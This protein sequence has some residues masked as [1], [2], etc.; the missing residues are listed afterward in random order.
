M[1]TIFWRFVSRNSFQSSETL[2]ETTLTLLKTVVAKEAFSLEIL[3]AVSSS[4]LE[5]GLAVSFFKCCNIF[6]KNTT[7]GFL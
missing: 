5:I 6:M 4:S 7:D 2:L 1:N 3:V